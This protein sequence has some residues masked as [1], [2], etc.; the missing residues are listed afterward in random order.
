MMRARSKVKT[1]V[2]NT[3]SSI[4][5]SDEPLSAETNYRTEFVAVLNNHPQGGF[6]TRTPTPNVTVADN[7]G[8]G[9]DRFGSFFQNG[10]GPPPGNPPPR[11]RNR[12]TGYQRGWGSQGGWGNPGWREDPYRREQQW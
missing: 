11:N 3:R 2:I 1:P 9:N 8:W 10:W 12:D 7:D 6:I 5:I 4:I